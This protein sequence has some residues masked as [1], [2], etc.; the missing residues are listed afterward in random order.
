MTDP[1]D[2]LSVAEAQDIVE[3]LRY[4][5]PPPGFVRQFT[6]GRQDE[7][8]SLERRLTKPDAG[9]G[10]LLQANYGSG[11][12]HLLRLI[13]DMALN[14]GFCVSYVVIG[15]QQ[16]VRFNRMDTVFG[17]VCRRLEIAPDQMGVRHLLQRF[18]DLSLH[19][20]GDNLQQERHAVTSDGRWDFSDALSGDAL[21]LAL[22]G[23][24]ATEDDD[25]RDLAVEFLSHPDRFRT[26]KKMLKD[27]LVDDLYVADPRGARE[28]LSVL[29][30]QSDDY[31][32]IWQSFN[33][34]DE[35][36]RLSGFRGLV[37]LFDEF[38]DVITNLN[39]RQLTAQALHNLFDFFVGRY[40]GG[41]FFAVTPEFVRKC[42]DLLL[43]KGV[44]DFPFQRL[45][46]LETFKL[47]PITFDEM[48][49]L[50]ARILTV[51]A[52]AFEWQP[53]ETL[54]FKKVAT[55]LIDEWKENAPER[56]RLACEALVTLLDT[57]LERIEG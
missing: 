13:R 16:G 29:T 38:E 53:E 26:Q 46:E 9:G 21:Y 41:N 28:I 24:C 55:F 42:Q 31:E 18:E 43:M 15:A 40:G 52:T 54:D 3:K 44:Y 11:K 1:L 20:G 10:L 17:E 19:G 22:R 39:N 50:A 7:L 14:A 47:S 36:A 5:T 27:R 56:V 35:L 49:S 25:V 12:T 23:F 57:E 8:A 2:A 33:G 48:L 34:L 51:H 6:V 37:L 4:G 45:D 32:G 30:L